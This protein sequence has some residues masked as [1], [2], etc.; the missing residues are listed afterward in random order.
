V[1]ATTEWDT[2]AIGFLDMSP[3]D[4]A[5]LAEVAQLLGVTKKTAQK[6][7]RRPDFP[8]P[9]G[10]VSTGFIWLRSDVKAWA[11][12]TLPLRTGRPRKEI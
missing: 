4:L 7:M 11:K 1:N 5:G 2:F 3:E 9:L 10:R 12:R 6:Y 8:E